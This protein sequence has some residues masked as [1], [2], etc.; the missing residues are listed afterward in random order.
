MYCWQSHQTLFCTPSWKTRVERVL[1]PGLPSL[2]TCTSGSNRYA[3]ISLSYFK[4]SIVV[5]WCSAK[6]LFLQTSQ[7]S[8]ENIFARVSFLVKLQIYSVWLYQERDPSTDVFYRTSFNDCFFTI[9]CSVHYPTATFR[10]FKTNAIHLFWL[11][12]FSA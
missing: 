2:I 9:T 7:N 5:W 4:V 12:I 11:S 6:K 1:L 10:F 8:Q 3:L